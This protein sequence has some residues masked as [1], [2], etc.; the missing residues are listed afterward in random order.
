MARITYVK[1]AQQRYE[2]VP[3]LDDEGNQKVV[4]MMR[5]DGTPKLTKSGRPVVMRLTVN[6]KTQPLPNRKCDKCG[7]EIAVGQPYKH[8]SPKS[9]PYGGRML[10]R[11]D[12]CPSWNVWEYSSSLSARVAEATHDFDVSNAESED[13]VTDALSTVAEAIREIASEKR[14]SAENMESGFGHA[15][16]QSDELNETADSLDSWAD[17][18]ENA[19]V[20]SMPEPEDEDCEDCEGTGEVHYVA[21]GENAEQT[22]QCENCV[23]TGKVEASEPNEEQMDEWRSEVES[24]CDIVNDCPV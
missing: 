24:A 21:D 10:I 22:V 16:Y 14:E 17:E 20:P 13:E 8:M 1:K 2:T 4:P 19:D 23:G 11:C 9:G 3:A 15:T 5:K 12:T 18:I 7:E 6:N